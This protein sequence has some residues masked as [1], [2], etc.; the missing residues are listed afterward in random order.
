[1]MMKRLIV[2]ALFFTC[3]FVETSY[4]A[5][6]TGPHTVGPD[7]ITRYADAFNISVLSRLNQMLNNDAA[8]ANVHRYIFPLNR[9]KETVGGGVALLQL[10]KKGEEK[11][12]PEKIQYHVE[13]AL[14]K[15]S[16]TILSTVVIVKDSKTKAPDAVKAAFGRYQELFCPLL[17]S[18]QLITDW[19]VM[20]EPLEPAAREELLAS[21]CL[22]VYNLA[23][24]EM[25]DLTGLLIEEIRKLECKK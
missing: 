7:Y 22:Y 12:S 16:D 9:S 24:K 2:A 6:K 17:A 13:A 21:I 19:C 4:A 5:S 3:C 10:V 25:Q 14:S 11:Y 23:T 1:M 8:F 15:H 20:P 18:D